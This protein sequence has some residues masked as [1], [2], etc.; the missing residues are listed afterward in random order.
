MQW[1]VY[2]AANVAYFIVDETIDKIDGL[3]MLNN[4][5][6]IRRLGRPHK[7]YSI[8]SCTGWIVLFC[9]G[10]I[11]VVF[12]LWIHLKWNIEIQWNDE[13]LS[14]KSMYASIDGYYSLQIM[15]N[16]K[17]IES[18]SWPYR[19]IKHFHSLQT[20]YSYSRPVVNVIIMFIIN[21]LQTTS[22]IIT[23]TAN[24]CATWCV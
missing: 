19:T 22:K 15:F 4:I 24:Y 17:V 6:V 21:Q 10:F 13:E 18:L 8:Y 12:I 2:H 7:V 16:F 1:Q 5:D 11:F 14:T 9:F 3:N 20:G 23:T